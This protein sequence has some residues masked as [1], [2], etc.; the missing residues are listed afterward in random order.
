MRPGKVESETTSLRPNRRFGG[1]WEEKCVLLW[2]LVGLK[3]VES[4]L[5]KEPR[6]GSVHFRCVHIERDRCPTAFE[7]W[8]TMTLKVCRNRR[9]AAIP[10]SAVR[11]RLREPLAVGKAPL[12]VRRRAAERGRVRA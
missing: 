2:C 3:L 6:Y 5:L 10:L 11:A 1:F 8:A 9:R 12:G 7:I 4:A